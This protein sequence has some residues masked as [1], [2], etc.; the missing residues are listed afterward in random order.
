MP[1]FWTLGSG[2]VVSSPYSQDRH[3]KK[4]SLE[5]EFCTK[6]C[7]QLI[8]WKHSWGGERSW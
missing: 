6:P 1:V 2:T 5:R 7:K 3:S 8:R 4:C